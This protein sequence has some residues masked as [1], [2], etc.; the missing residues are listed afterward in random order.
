V[1]GKE[2]VLVLMLVHLDDDDDS[3]CVFFLAHCV[4]SPSPRVVHRHRSPFVPS[5]RADEKIPSLR[6]SPPPEPTLVLLRFTSLMLI[7][8]RLPLLRRGLQTSAKAGKGMPPPLKGVRV[9]D[10]T[11]VLAGPQATVRSL[12]L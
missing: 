3:S 12:S 8:R 7:L 4:P 10:L 1:G 11:R 2:K 6:L 9:L 5:T